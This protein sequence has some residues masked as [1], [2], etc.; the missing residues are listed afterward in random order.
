MNLPYKS[1][2][3]FFLPYPKVPPIDQKRMVTF[4][5]QFTIST[6]KFLNEFMTNVESRFVELESKLRD[7]ETSLL[8][9]EAK[10]CIS[11]CYVIMSFIVALVY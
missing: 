4:I 7:V 8:I 6:V 5:N 1:I 10:V 3:I 2:T 9:V 11:D